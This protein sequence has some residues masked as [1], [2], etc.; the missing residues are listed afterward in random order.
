LRTVALRR[1]QGAAV[2]EP[3]S[4]VCLASRCF[5]RLRCCVG[6]DRDAVVREEEVPDR[7]PH[8]H[9]VCVLLVGRLDEI[10]D[11]ALLREPHRQLVGR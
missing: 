7:F 10:I 9:C 3:D 5:Q 11:E 1:E 2:L 6:V 8:R 4:E